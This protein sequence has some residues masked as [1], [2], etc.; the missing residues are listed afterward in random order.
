M[1]DLRE[2]IRNLPDKEV[3][4]IIVPEWMGVKVYVCTLNGR[5]REVLEKR[6]TEPSEDPDL[7]AYICATGLCDDKG[8]MLYDPESKEDL[9]E[10][11]A[12]SCSALNFVA[13][14]FMK[15]NKMQGDDIE[16][17]EKN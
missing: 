15:L 1:T 10:L 14:E 5:Q 11:N 4:E 2:Q 7:R 6:L 16:E 8:V 12:R 13:E 17:L 3:K 9:E